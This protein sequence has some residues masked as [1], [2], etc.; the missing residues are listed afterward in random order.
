MPFTANSEDDRCPQ[1]FL[2]N[3]A[4]TGSKYEDGYRSSKSAIEFV[5][6][7]TWNGDDAVL[8]A[9]SAPGPLIFSFGQH[10]SPRK[11]TYYHAYRCM[12]SCVCSFCGRVTGSAN[13]IT[14]DRICVQ[15][16][17]TK[18]GEGL[19]SRSKAKDLVRSLLKQ[20]AETVC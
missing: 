9:F 11:R 13:P 19:V 6:A 2:V 14:L 18:P 4:A 16:Y 10:D 7:T 12:A 17:K 3:T 15:C 1:R 20:F 8:E 5:Q